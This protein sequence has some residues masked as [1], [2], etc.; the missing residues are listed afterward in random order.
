[1]LFKEDQ[2][3]KSQIYRKFSEFAKKVETQGATRKSNNETDHEKSV[4]KKVN[5]KI[6]SQNTEISKDSKLK[7]ESSKKSSSESQSSK[8]ITDTTKKIT[9]TTQ[10]I[11]QNEKDENLNTNKIPRQG[12]ESDSEFRSDIAN[13][14]ARSLLPSDKPTIK[15]KIENKLPEIKLSHEH[16]KSDSIQISNLSISEK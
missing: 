6:F 3:P 14:S 9:D 4:K 2:I 10:K 15:E 8:K 5:I 1:M 16:S 7:Q 13:H 11:N 12:R